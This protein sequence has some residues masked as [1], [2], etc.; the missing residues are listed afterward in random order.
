MSAPAVA[1]LS[2]PGEVLAVVPSLCGFP[3]AESLVLLSLH[4]ARRC[5]GLTVRVDLPDEHAEQ[6]VAVLCAERVRSDGADD[7][8]VAV[9]SDGED[10]PG[11]VE[12]VRDACTDRGI[13]VREALHVRDGRWTSY[14][15]AG[16]C[17]P[18]SGTPLPHTSSAL[19]LLAAE[20]VGSGR[21]VLSSRDELVRALAP[22]A[23]PLADALARQHLADARQAWL[24]D[25][26]EQGA[27]ACR[28]RT[29]ALATRLLDRVADGAP[30][31]PADAA[32]LTVGLH[33]VLARD[34]L[35]TVM[36]TRSDELLSMLL[37]V[38]A[39]VVAPDDAPVCA[40]V[41]WVAYGRGQGALANVALDRTLAGSPD[42]S[43]AL[44]LRSALDGGL[45][46]EQIRRAARSTA[47]VLRRPARRLRGR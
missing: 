9:W 8:V 35:A 26:A 41:A 11:L 38:A 19:E 46:P 30:V 10:R 39:Q 25:R 12:C 6:D 23:P 31:S 5:L 3:P 28:A 47:G 21:A 22:P 34:G 20:Q 42:H 13:P 32:A 16:R 17:C 40:L 29:L 43:L 27:A 2:S 37:Q 14:T 4:G 1:R 36:L 45:P 44:L 24:R 33:D 15:C 18:P 7:V